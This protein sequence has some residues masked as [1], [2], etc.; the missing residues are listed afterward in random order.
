MTTIR[1]L[2][3]PVACILLGL[4]VGW[5]S[6]EGHK[7]QTVRLLDVVIIG[8]V[9]IAMGLLTWHVYGALAWLLVFI[10]ATTISYN[11]KNYLHEQT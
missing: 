7:T 6:T 4:V 2:V 9:M 8:P 3:L 5:I 10:G 1:S 11:L